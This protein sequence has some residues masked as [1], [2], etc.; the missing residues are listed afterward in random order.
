MGAP[1]V[2]EEGGD[3]AAVLKRALVELRSLRARLQAAEQGPRE[4]IA[5]VGIGCR[6]P[7]AGSPQAFWDLLRSGGDATR[8]IPADRWDAAAFY[9]PDVEAPGKM[10][11]RRGGFLDQVDGFDERFFNLSAREARYLDPQQRLLL[12]VSWE[13]LE[14]AAIAPSA[15][16]GS[17]TGVFIGISTSDYAHLLSTRTPVDKLDAY[18]GLGTG[19]SF[20]AGRLSYSLGLKGP[21]LAVDTACSSSLVAVHL[22]CQSLRS[23]ES[24]LALAAG[25]SLILAPSTQIVLCKGR[26]LA[27]D[28]RCKSF[29]AAADGYGR[30]EGCGVV[31]LRR[32]TD[33]MAAGDRV[34]AVIRGSAVNQDGPS[35]GLT[36]PSGAAQQA[37]I[38]DALAAAALAPADVAYVEAHGTGTPLGDPI[39]ARAL[40]AALGEGRARPLLLGSAKANIGHLEASAGIAG[41]IKTALTLY[42]G[43]LPPHLHAG[44]PSPHIDW[45]RL[46]LKLVDQR[47]PWPVPA[48]ARVAGVSSFGASGTNAHVI[49]S[50]PPVAASAPPAAASA[51]PA[52][53]PPAELLTLSAR[54][55]AAL[56]SLADRYAQHLAAHPGEALSDLCHTANRGRAALPHRLALVAAEPAV[57]GQ[58][59]AAFAAGELKAGCEYGA[60]VG[61]EPPKIAFLFTGQGAQYPGMGQELYASEPVFR[62]ALAQCEAL[63]APHLPRSLLQVLYGSDADRALL[64]ET[65]YAQPALFAIEWALAALLRS[66]GIR[67]AAVMGHS[68]GEYAAA[69]VAGVFRL[70]DGLRLIATRARLMQ[71]LPRTGAMAALFADEATVAAAI[72]EY[73]PALA[74][75]A[76]NAPTETVISGAAEAVAA[77][78]AALAARG[79]K[80]RPLVVSHAFHS[81]L[82]EPILDPLE[83]AAGELTLSPPQLSLISN[84]TGQAVGPGSLGPAYFRQHARAPVRFAAG[85]AA[86]AQQ[87][88]ALFVELGPSP[89]LLGMGRRCLPEGQGVWLPTLRRGRPESEQLLGCLGALYARGAAVDWGGVYGDAARRKLALPTYP[90]QRRRHWLD[91]ADPRPTPPGAP[92]ALGESAAGALLGR[93]LHSPALAAAVFES[94]LVAAALPAL[95][96]HRLYG[97]IVV[98]GVLHLALVGAAMQELGSAGRG[99]AFDEIQFLQPLILPETGARTLQTVITREPAGGAGF[100]LVSYAD[101]EPGPGP[102]ADPRFV[103]HT[104]GRVRPLTDADCAAPARPAGSLADLMQRCG[105]ERDGADFYARL[106]RI[107]E[108]YLGP[109]Y[110]TIERIWRRDGEAVVRLQLP[111]DAV[112]RPGDAGSAV[113]LAFLRKVS[114]GEV[115]GQALMPALPDYERVALDPE[116]TFVGQGVERSWELFGQAHRA[117]YCHALLRRYTDD[118]LCGDVW[119]L[120]AAGEVLG[121]AAGLRVR[122]VDR[123]LVRH[124]VAG[125]Q[126]RRRAA[127]LSRT[128][129]LQL[130]ASAQSQRLTD[131]LRERLAEVLGVAPES[132]NPDDTLLSLGMDS[133]MAVEL[134]NAL[135]AE[136]AVTLPAAELLLGG[137]LTLGG[138]TA[139]VLR[140]L[141]GS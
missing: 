57:L 4:P 79:I 35:S 137:G 12:E 58:R 120:D 17:R 44:T 133:L 68:V 127:A 83:R 119:L 89:V 43:E 7:G 93:R 20:A 108:H 67:P 105:E 31:V 82:I 26:A 5:V 88:C 9:D 132:V 90:F 74:I 99:L 140:A 91:E 94:Q 6:F 32:L 15:L 40:A 18:A 134:H 98:S 33:A 84:L 53:R 72:S 77:V 70:E 59:L 100:Q 96:D 112:L 13:A 110:R 3:R 49:L 2:G 22:A 136:L 28:G 66:W 36:V 65:L 41:L 115:Y 107:D 16:S 114:I 19:L 8:E 125:I 14:D 23:G 118:E 48:E 104:S 10:Y 63:L 139:R 141:G 103:V 101:A 39:E 109:S 21:S 106:W 11:C 95:I 27:A 73:G 117:R 124:A 87:G 126:R 69:C 86:L 92:A 135:R 56:R 1:E 128:E 24:Q 29:A 111:A 52:D 76:L 78:V 38:R 25:V 47:M 102:G 85:I 30:G 81:S 130:T 113:D 42:H 51:P 37:V 123:A 97:E 131:H 46:P 122:R 45:A 62:H 54:S 34:L 60:L 61:S 55:D 64:A 50:A 129:L 116:T 121:A 71:E 80:S 75:A 138:L